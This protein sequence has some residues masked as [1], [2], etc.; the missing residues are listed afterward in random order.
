MKIKLSLTSEAEI[1]SK[2]EWTVNVIR[3]DLDIGSLS[4]IIK[5]YAI[6]IGWKLI[7]I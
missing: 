3:C 1:K 6:I 7:E 4:A 5:V 2:R